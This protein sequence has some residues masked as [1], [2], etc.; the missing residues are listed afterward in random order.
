MFMLRLLILW[1]GAHSNARVQQCWRFCNTPFQACIRPYVPMK[2][3]WDAGQH[4]CMCVA[5]PSRA[6]WTGVISSDGS[7]PERAP[8]GPDAP[9]HGSTRAKW[10]CRSQRSPN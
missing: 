7:A 4:R 5:V 9:P 1:P 2:R 10:L 3:C 6:K 8:A